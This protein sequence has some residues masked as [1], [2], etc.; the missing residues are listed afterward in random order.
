MQQLAVFHRTYDE[1]IDLMVEARNYMQFVEARDRLH[2]DAI[3]ALRL[4]C[5][6]MRVTSRLTQVMAWLMM[7]RAVQEGEITPDEAVSEPNRLSGIEVCLDVSFA[8]DISLP[9]GLKS[10]LC[11]SHRLY[12]RIFHLEEQILGR[13]P[14]SPHRG[15][16]R[17]M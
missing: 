12:L 11:R 10:L 14:F 13:M 5:E 6:A 3:L 7:Q 1:T 17:A 9:R 2:S 4:S 16:P 8:E 15:R